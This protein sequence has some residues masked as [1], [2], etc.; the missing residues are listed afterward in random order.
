MAEVEQ[1]EQTSAPAGRGINWRRLLIRSAIG[2]AVVALV[3][4]LF[5]PLQYSAEVSLLLSDR[6]DVTASLTANLL[7]ITGAGAMGAGEVGQVASGLLGS[8]PA[9]DRLQVILQSDT[10]ALRLIRKY[11]LARRWDDTEQEAVLQLEKATNLKPLGQSGV[12]LTVTVPSASRVA[13]WLRLRSGTTE[14]EAPQ[15]CADM[16]NEYMAALDDWVQ[17]THVSD[18]K[19]TSDFLDKRQQEVARVLAGIEVQLEKLQVK[20]QLLDPESRAAALVDADKT[21]L[22]AY[23]AAEADDEG[24]THALGLAKPKLSATT[25][26]RITQDVTMRNPVLEP[27]EQQIALTQ[28][29]LET[30]INAGKS[31]NHPDVLDLQATLRSLQDQV[32][33]I[34]D[35]IEAGVTT[36]SNP[37][38]DAMVGRVVDLEVALVGAEARKKQYG[39]MLQQM[40]GQM[41]DLPPVA[42]EYAILAR[43]RQLESDLL[44][45]LAKQEQESDLEAQI[46]SSG[47]FDVLDAAVP[48]EKK[49]GPST[50]INS[51][52]AFVLLALIQLLVVAKRRG[53]FSLEALN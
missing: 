14:A 47:T 44:V 9:L 27:L 19:Q 49:S 35:Q 42:R 22:E 13:T 16:G 12:L 8:N 43:Q 53:M 37:I 48:P 45:A 52:I 7:G 23:V 20:Y 24:A 30:A 17:A 36:A 2:A 34:K 11:D 21:A 40:E 26:M 32:A 39:A 33:K 31:A 28:A 15:L 5:L 38:Y 46:Q 3:T 29:A 10:V 50:A 41:R 6:P 4:F 25:V 51:L 18:A 1:T